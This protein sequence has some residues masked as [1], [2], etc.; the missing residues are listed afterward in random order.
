MIPAD[1]QQD[2]PTDTNFVALAA[3]CKAEGK[4]R[5]QAISELGAH[6]RKLNTESAYRALCMA[7]AAV[8]PPTDKSGQHKWVNVNAPPSPPTVDKTA[9]AKSEI[10]NGNSKSDS[11]CPKMSNNENQDYQ[12]LSTT[13]NE[14]HGKTPSA[15]ASAAPL[16]SEKEPKPKPKLKPTT[17]GEVF[18][19]ELAN[20]MPSSL[21]LAGYLVEALKEAGR[22]LDDQAE[23]QSE[24]FYFVRLVKAH[25]D[26]VRKD[27][28]QAVALVD[29]TMAKLVKQLPAKE[30][31]DPWEHY[32]GVG[33]EDVYAEFYDQWDKIRHLPGFSP[34][35][36]ALEMAKRRPLSV[37]A[38]HKRA[39]AA[40]YEVFISLAGWLQVDMGDTPIL[41]P[42]EQVA[43]LLGVTPKSVSRYRQWA[44]ADGYLRE[45]REAQFGGPGQDGRATEFVFDIARWECLQSNGRNQ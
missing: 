9:H 22:R 18:E 37:L 1:H 39:F 19:H 23:W 15:A 16:P 29:K 4:T 20:G 5:S 36:N 38:E 13:S 30:R 35:A 31:F 3:R 2:N 45:L 17:A 8:Y 11:T 6:T 26:M 25:P 41:L 27:A 32:L 12:R 10:V 43:E 28:D 33:K 34:L 40:N 24:G 42:V 14:T 7:I 44:V 21:P